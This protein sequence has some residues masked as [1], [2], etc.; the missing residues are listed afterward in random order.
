MSSQTTNL[1]LVKPAVTE[2]IDISVI[3]GN[4]DIIDA[5]VG[6]LNTGKANAADVTTALNAMLNNILGTGVTLGAGTVPAPTAENKL[7]L[8]NITAFDSSLPTFGR[9]TVG[10]SAAVNVL[11]LPPIGATYGFLLEQ[12]GFF[13]AAGRYTQKIWFNSTQEAG[14]YYQRSKYSNGWGAWSRYTGE[15]VT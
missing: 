11:N 12:S 8:D 4:M 10:A 15:A 14:R 9:I 1:N 2:A 7:D 3:N 13:S 5:A 6:L